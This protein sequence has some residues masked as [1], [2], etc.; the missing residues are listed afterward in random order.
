[1]GITMPAKA[2][3]NAALISVGLSFILSYRSFLRT[4]S[5]GGG[6]NTV[7]DR[8]YLNPWGLSF[9]ITRDTVG[10]TECL[11]M[12][13]L[14]QCMPLFMEPGIRTMDRRAEILSRS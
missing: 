6:A 13:G 10:Y 2:P 8:E 3:A 11:G 14:T 7:N 12:P 9:D 4:K 1:M 5:L